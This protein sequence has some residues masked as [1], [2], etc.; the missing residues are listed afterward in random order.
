MS[1]SIEDWNHLRDF[2]ALAREGT[3]AKA[4]A[5]RDVD[6]TTVFRHLHT[7]ERELGSSLFERRGRGYVLTANGES[8]A[9]HASR[10]E[11]QVHLLERE[12]AG[13]DQ[14]LSGSIRVTTTDTVAERLLVPMLPRFYESF[15][16]IRIDLLLDDRIFRL[17]RGEAD[18]ALRPDTRPTEDD[19]VPRL[20]S[21]MECALYASERYLA[22][23]GWPRRRA[24]LKKHRLVDLDETLAH[25]PYARFVLQFGSSSNVVFR[26]SSF[27]GVATAIEQGVGIGVAP[28]FL[29][30]ERPSV[31]RL[32]GL[33]PSLQSALWL[34]IH[35]DLRHMARVRA[36]VD[37]V[38]EAI[39]RER[40]LLEGR[41][42]QRVRAARP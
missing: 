32:F 11:E 30:D 38:T 35:R 5:R 21:P 33:E 39:E 14:A 34:L 28:C 1:A 8:L 19:V 41:R 15:P 13:R 3:L 27:L 26:S 16:G 29:M 10:V 4:G 23:A 22:Q 20:L 17:G 18:V 37:F 6:P 25:V 12:M 7:L 2:L 40:D 36:F 42:G 24:D 9:E 31:V